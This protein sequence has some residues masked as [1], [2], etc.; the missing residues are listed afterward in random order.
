MGVAC[1]GEQMEQVWEVE[2]VE[3][4]QL[5][6]F[7]WMMEFT[8]EINWNQVRKEQ[9]K[10]KNSDREQNNLCALTKTWQ[11]GMSNYVETF[12]YIFGIKKL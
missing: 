3:E 10:K 4:E 2:Q 9:R 8:N 5:R 11:Y 6:G 7:G 12:R 1:E